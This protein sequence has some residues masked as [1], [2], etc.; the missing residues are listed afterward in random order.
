M[1]STNVIHDQIKTFLS[2]FGTRQESVLSPFL[3]TIIVKVLAGAVR[4]LKEIEGI[5]MQSINILKEM[6]IRIASTFV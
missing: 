1:G 4:Q 3:F 5:Q 2:L 6:S